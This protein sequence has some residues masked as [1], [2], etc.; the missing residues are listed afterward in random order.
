MM[1]LL[2][3]PHLIRLIKMQIRQRR[4]VIT[5]QLRLPL[6]RLRRKE[7]VDVDISVDRTRERQSNAERIKLR[8]D[9]WNLNSYEDYC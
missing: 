7:A 6:F 9:K 3:M 1:R 5:K 8:F 2:Q 4:M